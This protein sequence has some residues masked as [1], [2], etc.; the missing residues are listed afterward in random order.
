MPSICVWRDGLAHSE[1]PA[2]ALLLTKCR[3]EGIGLLWSAIIAG[4][5]G[6]KLMELDNE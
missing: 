1:L 3:H 6:Q 2:T 4:A 5:Q